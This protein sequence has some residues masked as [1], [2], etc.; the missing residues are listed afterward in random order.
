MVDWSNCP[1]FEWRRQKRIVFVFETGEGIPRMSADGWKEKEGRVTSGRQLREVLVG[2]DLSWTG[3]Q[4]GDQCR[5]C[6]WSRCL[7]MGV[8]KNLV[9]TLKRRVR[10]ESQRED[11]LDA[12]RNAGECKRVI[13][14]TS[15]TGVRNLKGGSALGA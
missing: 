4:P 9:G 11:R 5:H 2:D 8:D 12:Y 14:I 13:I 1:D 10:K 15:H 3:A 6:R 7:Q